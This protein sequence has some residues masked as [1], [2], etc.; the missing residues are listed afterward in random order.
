MNRSLVKT[1]AQLYPTLTREVW[2]PSFEYRDFEHHY[3][4]AS[5]NVLEQEGSPESAEYRRVLTEGLDVLLSG[6]KVPDFPS[7]PGCLRDPWCRLGMACQTHLY[8]F[9]MTRILTAF[10]RIF[11]P[12]STEEDLHDIAQGVLS[13]YIG[14]M[15]CLDGC[16]GQRSFLEQMSYSSPYPD[17][18]L[19]RLQEEGGAVP[20]VSLESYMVSPWL[21]RVEEEEVMAE[22][23]A[24][25]VELVEEDPTLARLATFLTAFSPV[26]RQVDGL[27]EGALRQYRHR[28]NSLLYDHLYTK[29]GGDSVLA[30]EKLSR[31]TSVLEQLDRVGSNKWLFTDSFSTEQGAL[32]LGD[33]EVLPLDMGLE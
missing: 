33:V 3:R 24:R 20:A 11:L 1:A 9:L 28:I 17:T 19:R 12:S 22:V 7:C 31:M 6:G 13:S 27:E 32:D 10:L 5:Q 23:T 2:T 4:M 15:I 18:C 30:S 14:L 21:E 16:F 29:H 25:M 8:R 26:K